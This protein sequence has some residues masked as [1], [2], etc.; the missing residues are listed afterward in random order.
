[1]P[2]LPEGEEL[3]LTELQRDGLEKIYVDAYILNKSRED[4]VWEQEFIIPNS[5]DYVFRLWDGSLRKLI[6]VEIP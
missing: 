3:I 2:L 1:M 4:V 5:K 6:E